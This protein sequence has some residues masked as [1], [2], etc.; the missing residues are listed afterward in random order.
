MQRTDPRVEVH[1][2][3]LAL[4]VIMALIDG[5]LCPVYDSQGEPLKYSSRY[6]A[7]KALKNAG[8]SHADFVHKS[9]Y[10]EMIGAPSVAGGAEMRESIDLA[11]VQG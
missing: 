3:E 1:S 9:T 5:E 8:L 4:Y 10:D 7:L 6:A 11:R 2:M